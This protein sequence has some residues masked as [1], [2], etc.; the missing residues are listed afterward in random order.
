ME[1]M[2]NINGDSGSIVMVDCFFCNISVPERAGPKLNVS[3]MQEVGSVKLL[4]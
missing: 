2:R 1:Q 4:T 3:T